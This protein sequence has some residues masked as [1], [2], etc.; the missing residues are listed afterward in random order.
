MEKVAFNKK[1]LFF[2]K[3]IGLKFEKGSEMLQLEYSL[4][5]DAVWDSSEIRS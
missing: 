3:Q 2:H 4:Y 5:V 1:A